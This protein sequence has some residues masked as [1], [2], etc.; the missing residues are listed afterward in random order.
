MVEIGDCTLKG[1]GLLAGIVEGPGAGLA[2]GYEGAGVVSAQ[3]GSPH[4]AAWTDHCTR[5]GTAHRQGPGPPGSCEPCSAPARPATPARGLTPPSLCPPSEASRNESLPRG[6]CGVPPRA[7]LS[8]VL[9]KWGPCLSAEIRY[10]H[11]DDPKLDEELHG[12]ELQAPGNAVTGLLG[13]T[14]F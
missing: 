7:W 2:L 8:L 10:T 12:P 6:P 4:N 5:G 3:R 1:Q 14:A 9:S 13:S 11:T